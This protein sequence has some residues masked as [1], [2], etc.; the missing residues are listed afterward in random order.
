MSR[1]YSH[2]TTEQRNTIKEMLESG[3]KKTDIAKSLGVHNATVYRE[4]DRGSKDG[5]YNP[6]YSEQRYRSE[7]NKKGSESIFSAD[8]ELAKYVAKLILEDRMS[9]AQIITHL[10]SSLPFETLP[11]SKN[12]IYNAID[13]ELIPNV[14]RKDLCSDTTTVYND[15][16]IHLSKWVRESLIIN[17]GDELSFEVIDNKIIFSKPEGIEKYN[18]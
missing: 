10:H 12:T 9:P 11:K 2:L 8:S 15:G 13:A 14:T 1:T 17:D 4:I 16:T 5:N 7:L 3:Y 6:T 18:K